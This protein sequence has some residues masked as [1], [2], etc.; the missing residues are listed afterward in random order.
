MDEAEKEIQL[1]IK[2]LVNRYPLIRPA[3][4]SGAQ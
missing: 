3:V 1:I 2:D 4:P